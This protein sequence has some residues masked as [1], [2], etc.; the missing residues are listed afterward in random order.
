MRQIG[1]YIRANEYE[2]GKR[3]VLSFF[4]INDTYA[5]LQWGWNFDFVPKGTD[6][7]WARTDK[8]IYTHI[9]EVSPDFYKSEHNCRE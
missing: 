1:D 9:F 3:R 2:E 7:V 4:G 5:T 6:A 8:S